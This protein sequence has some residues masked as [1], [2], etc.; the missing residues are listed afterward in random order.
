MKTK[1]YPFFF[2]LLAL[3]SIITCTYGAISWDSLWEG[4]I[5]RIKGESNLW[6]PLL[7]ERVPRLL[8]ILCTGA[9]LAASGAIMQALF[10]NPLAAP[11][12]LGITSGGSL[13]AIPVFI[14]GWHVAYPFAIPIAAFCGCLLTLL[15]VYCLALRQGAIQMQ[16]LILTGI[17]ISSL[18]LSIQGAILYS[19]RD[20]WQLIQIITEWE[21]GSTLD[22]SWKEVHMQLPLTLIGLCGALKYR[23]ELNLLSLGDEEAFHLGVDVAKVRWRLI[24]CVAL[25]TGGVIAAVGM[26]MFYGLILPHILRK[27]FGADNARLIPLCIAYGSTL[28]LSLDL[29]LRIFEIKAFALGN[30][31]AVFGGITMVI[32]LLKN[33]STSRTVC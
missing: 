5:A 16:S 18:L 11:S 21:A 14:L 6:N 20:H 26:I 27:I 31:T 23:H 12:I 30:I 10:Q 13:L 24:L 8:V 25:M 4:A 7:D 9:S 1:P 15:L 2:L 19:L 28:L 32:L 33:A 17:A 3:G 22:K 29:F